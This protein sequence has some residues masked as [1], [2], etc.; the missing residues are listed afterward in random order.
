MMLTQQIAMIKSFSLVV[1]HIEYSSLCIFVQDSLIDRKASIE[2]TVMKSVLE[3]NT[4]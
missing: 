2:L 1:V 4:F 3:T